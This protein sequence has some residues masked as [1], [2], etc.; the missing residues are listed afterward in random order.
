VSTNRFDEMAATW[1][2]DPSKVDR[3]RAVAE[4]IRS[5]LPLERGMRLL[6]Y[7]AGTGLVT[8]H[9]QDAV[10]AVTLADSSRG[11]LDALRAKV[12][13]GTFPDGRAWDLDLG[14]DAVPDERF[15]VIVT[16][17]TLHHIPDLDPVLAGFAAM[18]EPGGHLA[19]VDLE[20]EDGSFHGEDFDGHRGFPR[21]DLARQLAVAGFGPP[22]FERVY[23]ITKNDRD[24]GLFLATC[25]RHDR[26][27]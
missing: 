18:L 21:D 12:A 20:H 26:G 2:D 9:L 14:R 8:Q 23:S 27:A 6:E 13:A 24:Y 15:D 19:A 4:A 17:M 16:V 11:M 3:A 1:D 7:G 5:A 22:R 10:G 25:A